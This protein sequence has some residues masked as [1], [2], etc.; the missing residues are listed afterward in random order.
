MRRKK[1]LALPIHDSIIV[2]VKNLM[3]AKKTM[4]DVYKAHMKH[5]CRIK[6]EYPVA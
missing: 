5:D 1:I 2:E 3:K 4:G 6:I